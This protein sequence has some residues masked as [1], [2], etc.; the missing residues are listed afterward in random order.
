MACFGFV[1][2]WPLPDFSLPSFIARI[3]R[4]TDFEAFGLYL[5]PLLFLPAVFFALVLFFTA[6]IICPPALWE[7][8]TANEVASRLS[9]G[10]RSRQ[11]LLHIDPL[12]RIDARITGGTVL[13]VFF[14]MARL[15]E[16]FE[17][18]VGDRVG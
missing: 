16:A 3:S 17:R 6:G 12:R 14:A 1:T 7:A 9:H 11:N 8:L 2:F 15:L 4:S 5:R 18:Q 10:C 13:V